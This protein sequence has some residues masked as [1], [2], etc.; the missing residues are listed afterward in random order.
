M[1]GGFDMEN[2]L[3]NEDWE[4][5]V[6]FL[7]NGWQ[8]KAK[9]F[10]LFQRIRKLQNPSDLLKV[11]LIHLADTSSLAETVTK[12][13]IYNIVNISDVALL[14]K[15]KSSSEWLRWMAVEL[16]KRRGLCVKP[17]DIFSNYNIRTID[18]SVISEPGSTGTDWRLHFSYILFKLKCDEYKITRKD[19]GE[20][21]LNFEVKPN[22][23]LIGDRAYGRY[24][25]M[26]YVIR[27][28]GHFITRYMNKSFTVYDIDGKKLQIIDKIKD[29]PVGQIL[30]FKVLAG[31]GNLPN[32]PI[33]FCVLKKRTT[34]GNNSVKKAL[35]EMK[36]KQKN[37]NPTTL[38]LHR[39]IIVMTS[40]PETISADNILELYRLR[41][42]IEIS[43]KRLKSIFLL[44]Y[45]PKKNINSCRA[46]LNGKLFVAILCQTMADESYLFSP[47]GY[48]I[49]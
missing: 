15:I 19:V 42:Q 13:K 49:Q 5:I 23:L 38:E 17:P 44:S 20:T 7:P 22:D 21:F 41:W 1:G 11:L 9:E 14:K 28:G 33:R 4:T 46:W 29:L 2:I 34:E 6:K 16:L 18:A 26:N 48:P 39:Y 37:I 10:G 25:S 24:K 32:I 31:S 8:E 12:A 40:L 30:E 27:K 36:K 43:F 45:L 35:R 47:W 3:K